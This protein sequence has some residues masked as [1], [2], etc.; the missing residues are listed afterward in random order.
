MFAIKCT[1]TKKDG[2]IESLGLVMNFHNGGHNVVLFKNREL[3]QKH[4]SVLKQA[5]SSNMSFETI[6]VKEAVNSASIW[7]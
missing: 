5:S 2:S 7:V 1:C 3:A 6:E 4:I